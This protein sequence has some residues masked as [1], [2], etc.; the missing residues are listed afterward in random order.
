MKLFLNYHC[1]RKAIPWLMYLSISVYEK[2]TFLTQITLLCM[3]NKLPYSCTFFLPCQ[4]V[5][6][7]Y[8]HIQARAKGSNTTPLGKDKHKRAHQ[9][10]F[11][12]VVSPFRFRKGNFV[13]QGL[14]TSSFLKVSPTLRKAQ[15]IQSFPTDFPSQSEWTPPPPIHQVICPNWDMRWNA[16]LPSFISPFLVWT[17]QTVDAL[18]AGTICWH[19]VYPPSHYDSKNPEST[20]ES[21]TT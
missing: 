1:Q 5:W 16:L 3:E 12:W 19:I 8:L 10:Q 7:D 2:Q 18:S 20:C 9:L 6:V 14:C 17:A 11:L 21:N 13:R 15:H 4:E